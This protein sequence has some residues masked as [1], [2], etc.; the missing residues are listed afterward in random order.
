MKKSTH[1]YTLLVKTTLSMDEYVAI[2]F[3]LR[4]YCKWMNHHLISM[5]K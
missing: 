5:T 1:S 2:G 3:I 4:R